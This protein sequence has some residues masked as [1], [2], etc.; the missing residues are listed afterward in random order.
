MDRDTILG[1]SVPAVLVR[2]VLLSL[3]VGITLTWFG[4]TPDNLFDQIN[5]LLRWL[6]ELGFGWIESAF[7]YLIL[8]AMVVVPIWLITR[9]VHVMN[10]R[11]P[12]DPA[13]P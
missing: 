11:R 7:K 13:K 8:G 10:K 1:G 5:A 9:L 4:I 3:V 6:Y 2:L 12:D